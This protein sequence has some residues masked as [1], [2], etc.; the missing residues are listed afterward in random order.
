MGR[1]GQGRDVEFRKQKLRF[2]EGRDTVEDFRMSLGHAWI[3]VPV[4]CYTECNKGM[5]KEFQS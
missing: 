4:Q 3:G 5:E 2:G 1:V